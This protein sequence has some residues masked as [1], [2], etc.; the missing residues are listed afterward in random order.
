MQLIAPARRQRPIE[1]D[2]ARADDELVQHVAEQLAPHKRPR[3]I[4]RVAE[5]PRN[6][7]GKVQK[8]RLLG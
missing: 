2:H 8:K 7:L 4:T 1:A 6:A 3:A 5:L